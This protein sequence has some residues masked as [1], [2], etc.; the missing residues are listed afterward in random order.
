[1]R[2]PKKTGGPGKSPGGSTPPKGSRFTKGKSGNPAGRPKG[3][4]NIRTL[5]MEA[6][7]NQVSVTIAGTRRRISAAQATALQLALKAAR[8]NQRAIIT[9]LDRI[10]QIETEAVAAKPAQFTLSDADVE[11][12]RAAYERMKQCNPDKSED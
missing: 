2:K 3:S 11:V 12:L 9:F 6:A 1:M 7:R 5:I 4:R 8:G 10:D